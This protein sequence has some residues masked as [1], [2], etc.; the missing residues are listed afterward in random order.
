MGTVMSSAAATAEG[1]PEGFVPNRL[2]AGWGLGSFATSTMLNGVAVVMLFYLVNFAKVEP[3]VAGAL[4]FGAKLLDVFTDPPMGIISDRTRSKLGRRRPYMLGASFFCGLAFA[5]LFNIPEATV[6]LTVVYTGFALA[7]YAVAYTAFQVPYMA[8]P[9]E[10]TDDY[11][12]RTKIMSWR[13]IFMTIGNIVGFAGVPVL[14]ATLGEGREAYGTM[15]LIVGAVI[16]VAMFTCF[17][18]TGGARQTESAPERIGLKRHLAMLGENRPLLILIGTKIAIY[19]GLSSNIAVALFFISSVLKMG[20]AQF[21]IYAGVSALTTIAFMPVC[22]WFARKIGKKR[23]Y[24]ISLIGFCCGILT[25]LLA[26]PEE[27]M[28]LFAGRGFLIGVFGAGA[29]LYG[30]SMLVDTFA[31]D[32]KLTGIRRE[33]VLAASFSFVEKACMAIGPL[34][35]GVLLSSMGFDKNLAPSADQ[36]ASAVQAMHL[37]FIWVPILCQIVSI[38]LLKYYTLDEK[39]LGA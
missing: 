20:P 17:L 6:N 28:V 36:S 33:G 35:V 8:M 21:G 32:Y 5:I 38:T 23:A 14:V 34:I 16:T 15:G 24:V 3:F 31:W 39:D 37:G 11:H 30:Q 25:W 29:H 2:A 27:S 18:T 7:L 1:R 26:T 13:V 19:V 10:M 22:A 9:A 12:Q 4:L